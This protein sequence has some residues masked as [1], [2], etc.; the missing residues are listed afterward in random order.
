MQHGGSDLTFCERALGAFE[1]Q[2]EV[3]RI[4]FFRSDCQ[5]ACCF[6]R[7]GAA[8]H[9]SPIRCLGRVIVARNTCSAADLFGES[10]DGVQEIHIVASEFVHTLQ[11]GYQTT[12]LRRVA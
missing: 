5:L 3:E 2:L 1:L 12:S 7:Q 4:E 10:A 11:R 6:L 9:Q 8:G